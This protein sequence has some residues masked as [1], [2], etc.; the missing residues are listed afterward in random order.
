MACGVRVCEQPLSVCPS[1]H[2][3]SG[4]LRQST[5]CNRATNA[6]PPDL[7]QLKGPDVVHIYEL[8]SRFY[9]YAQYRY[10][11]HTHVVRT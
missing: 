6:V 9:I 7:Q 4:Q 3:I 5:A 8:A 10:V 11:V 2:Y 1:G